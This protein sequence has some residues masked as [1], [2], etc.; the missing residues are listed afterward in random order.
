VRIVTKSLLLAVPLCLALG[1]D[2]KTDDKKADDKK[3]DDKKA[4][5]DKADKAPEKPA[6]PEKPAP[7][8]MKEHDLTSAG[9]EWEGW[10]AQGAAS[11]EVMG[12]LGKAARIAGG[13]D[14]DFDLL[15][16][17]KKTDFAES[18]ANV[19][20]G[21]EANAG[22][23]VTFTSDT[24]ELLEWTTEGEGWSSYSFE[25]N[26]TVGD[27]EVTCKT[28]HGTKTPEARDQHK[29]ACATLAKK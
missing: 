26:M 21:A 2:K 25:M 22:T 15:F 27:R 28:L 23:K 16:V 9:A 17:P 3:A 29:A 13:K 5:A 4:E 6:E 18:K 11:G 19:E 8:E 10:V 24:P 12:D 20:K 7:I 14:T 1:C